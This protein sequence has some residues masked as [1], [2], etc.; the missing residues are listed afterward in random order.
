MSTS[1][2]AGRDGAYTLRFLILPANKY[3]STCWR[4]YL[5]EL[6]FGL[7]S[8]AINRSRCSYDSPYPPKEAYR[9]GTWYNH[10]RTAQR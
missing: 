2:R 1:D 4:S 10:D 7:L 8:I 9:D 3:S 5:S 6:R